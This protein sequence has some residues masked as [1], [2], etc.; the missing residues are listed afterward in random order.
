MASRIIR[1]SIDNFLLVAFLL[2]FWNFS[3]FCA[4]H[5]K[6]ARPLQLGKN[7]SNSSR[8]PATFP[9]FKY[10]YARRERT[11]LMVGGWWMRRGALRNGKL[12]FLGHL[13]TFGYERNRRLEWRGSFWFER[14]DNYVFIMEREFVDCFCYWLSARIFIYLSPFNRDFL[15]N[16]TKD[17]FVHDNIYVGSDRLD[18]IYTTN[19]YYCNYLKLLNY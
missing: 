8:F 2:N 6:I 11:E 18:R 15:I 12:K 14:G 13:L 7:K 17:E 10:S 19:Y 3:F 5:W 1:S 16:E 9:S 4:A